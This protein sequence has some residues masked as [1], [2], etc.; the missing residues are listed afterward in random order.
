MQVA[1]AAERLAR[2]EVDRAR[3]GGATWREVGEAFGTNR[4]AAHERFSD[5]PDGRHTRSFR[6]NR[7]SRSDSSG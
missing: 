3:R 7:Q 4:Q 1:A 6:A 2:I 5:G